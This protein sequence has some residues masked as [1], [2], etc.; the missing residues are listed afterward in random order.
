MTNVNHEFGNSDVKIHSIK[1]AGRPVKNRI[2]RFNI[3]EIDAMMHGHK[4]KQGGYLFYM[5]N[6]SNDVYQA[7]WFERKRLVG[8]YE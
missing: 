2:F 1:L 6:K 8:K 5:H 3:F 7:S 4:I